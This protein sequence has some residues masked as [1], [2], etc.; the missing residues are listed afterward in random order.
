M[1]RDFEKDMIE[2]ETAIKS[3]AERDNAFTLSVLQRAK[4][5]II[6]QKEKLTAYENTDMKPEE[7]EKLKEKNCKQKMS[8]PN[9]NV[10]CCPECGEALNPMWDYCS[11]CGQHVT[12]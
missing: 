1:E 5:L 8:K 7:I 11:W 12:D 9:P 2:L 4:L 6:Q 3:N 10:Y